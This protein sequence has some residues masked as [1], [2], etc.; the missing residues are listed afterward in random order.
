MFEEFYQNEYGLQD[1]FVA[2]W[3]VVSKRF[4]AN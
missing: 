1:K 2:Y 3:D 4:A